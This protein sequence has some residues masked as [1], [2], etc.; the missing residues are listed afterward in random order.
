MPFI[1]AVTLCLCLFLPCIMFSLQLLYMW[2]EVA[3]TAGT[4]V[5]SAETDIPAYFNQGDL[6][7]GLCFTSSQKEHPASPETVT[8]VKSQCAGNRF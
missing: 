6:V 1:N 7:W 4:S 3:G 8:A 2:R 5:D